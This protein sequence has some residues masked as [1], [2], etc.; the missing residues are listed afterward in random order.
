M[1]LSTESSKRFERDTDIDNMMKALDNL[2]YLIAELGDGKIVNGL[3]DS[4]D[5]VKINN[6]QS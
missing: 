6:K 2:A 4:Y 5:K 3:I 1:D